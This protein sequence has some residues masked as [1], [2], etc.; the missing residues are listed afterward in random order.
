[1]SAEGS[2]K[3]HYYGIAQ[4]EIEVI[5]GALKDVF[6][7]VDEEQLPTEDTQY[8]SMVEMEFPIADCSKK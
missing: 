7:R 4:F 1:M 5:Y 8:V 2:A 6:G 3:F